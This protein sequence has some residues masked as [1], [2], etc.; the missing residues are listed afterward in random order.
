MGWREVSGYTLDDLVSSSG[1]DFKS[2]FELTVGVV[3][4]VE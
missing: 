3:A 4:V 1:V 2:L